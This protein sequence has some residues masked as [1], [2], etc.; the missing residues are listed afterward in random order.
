MTVVGLGPFGS[1]AAGAI[2]GRFGARTA[3]VAG[4][5]VAMAASA[6]FGV[7]ERRRAIGV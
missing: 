6:A 7:S 2:A 5:V 3:V 1:L 4:G